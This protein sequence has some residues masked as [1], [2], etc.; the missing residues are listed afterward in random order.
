[1][2]LTAVSP[3]AGLFAIV[4]VAYLAHRML[5]KPIITF[6]NSIKI[7]TQA[8]FNRQHRTVVVFGTVLTLIFIVTFGLG[9]SSAF[10]QPLILSLSAFAISLLL[11]YLGSKTIVRA[12]SWIPSRLGLSKVVVG[13]VFVASVTAL[14]EL[15]S[16]MFAVFLG[17]SHLALGNI[18]GSNIYN[19]PLIIGI[20]GLIREF[21]IKD[22]SINKECSFMIG[23]SLLFTALILT[24][25]NI[26]QWMGAIFLA[27]YPIFIYYSLRNE[28][29]NYEEKPHHSLTKTGANLI[30]GG[31][32][33]LTGTFLLIY[34]ALNIAQIFGLGHF[35]VGLTIVAL[36][37][38][39]PE[40]AVS[41]AATMDNEHDISIG[42]VIGD[43]IITI[44]LV[45]GLVAIIRPS[46]VPS[47][48]VLTT[49]PLMIIATLMLFMVNKQSY[50]ITKRWG[51]IMLT[52][53]LS[54]FIIQTIYSI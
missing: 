34:S 31:G 50:K 23:L 21:K 15:F 24:T 45:F 41:V 49:A 28:N 32:A 54:I 5:K 35:Y 7:I 53:A 29:H 20:I 13:T 37:C 25:G 18:I 42:N 6:P 9:I 1:M 39:I 16:S 40:A 14:P 2:N 11:L 52:I 30:L 3:I 19:I 46:N 47:F 48:E 26:T 44:T 43:N 8:Y 27:F 17:S 10:V 22:S 36:G 38:I 51:F 4:F 12:A 33:L